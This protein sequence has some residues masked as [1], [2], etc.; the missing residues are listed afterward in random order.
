MQERVARMVETVLRW[1]PEAVR[2]WLRLAERA[3]VTP[4]ASRRDAATTAAVK[5]A[6]LGRRTAGLRRVA[7]STDLAGLDAPEDAA[8]DARHREPRG[9]VLYGLSHLRRVGA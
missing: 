7:A 5:Q 6:V 8:L 9:A 2:Q 3:A 4:G 1:P